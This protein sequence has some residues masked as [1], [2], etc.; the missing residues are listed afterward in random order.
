MLIPL[1]GTVVQ[2]RN[3]ESARERNKWLIVPTKWHYVPQ[4]GESPIETNDEFTSETSAIPLDNLLNDSVS[5]EEFKKFMRGLTTVTYT[6]GPD[7]YKNQMLSNESRALLLRKLRFLYDLNHK[8]QLEHV[9]L[10]AIEG[11]IQW[12]K[13]V[14]ANSSIRLAEFSS[15]IWLIAKY[16][17]GDPVD[18]WDRNCQ[19]LRKDADFLFMLCRNVNDQAKL[20][21]LINHWY[22]A[23]AGQLRFTMPNVADPWVRAMIYKW[24]LGT[25]VWTDYI[26]PEDLQQMRS[27][28]ASMKYFSGV[29]Q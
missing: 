13:F 26:N 7:I 2:W 1:E 18:Y 8:L 16:E 4:A 10:L 6:T 22:G 9:V 3:R 29:V 11:L 25:T 21:R 20:Q 19:Q 24:Y 14:P 23:P 28:L 5:E 27:I 15:L 17:S 12:S